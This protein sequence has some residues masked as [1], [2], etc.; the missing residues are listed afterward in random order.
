MKNIKNIKKGQFIQFFRL[1]IPLKKV[2]TDF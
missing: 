1:Q 2:T